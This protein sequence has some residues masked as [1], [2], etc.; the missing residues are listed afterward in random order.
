MISLD[1]P[2]S[3]DVDA[4]GGGGGGGG[5]GMRGVGF[6]IGEDPLRTRVQDLVTAFLHQ[7]WQHAS[8]NIAVNGIDAD[9]SSLPLP[10]SIAQPHPHP[11]VS[12]ST[13]TS[14]S[15]VRPDNA[16]QPEQDLEVE[17]RDYVYEAYDAGLSARLAELHAEV[18]ALTVSV[19][20]LR[21]EGP[22]RV[23]GKVGGEVEGDDLDG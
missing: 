14:T 2:A 13:P 21:R 18:E 12:T 22:G 19:A 3:G 8:Q 10:P 15:N 5:G 23:A 11:Q 4:R 16:Q 20:R 1:G 9:A 17:G 7:T 6:G